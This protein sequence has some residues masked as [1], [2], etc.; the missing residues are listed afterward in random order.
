MSIKKFKK[1]DLIEVQ[2]DART[3][4]LG[5]VVDGNPVSLYS[6]WTPGASMSCLRALIDGKVEYVRIRDI[7]P[8]R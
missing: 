2:P 8:R 6:S 3:P 7:K 1:G 4:T 5:I